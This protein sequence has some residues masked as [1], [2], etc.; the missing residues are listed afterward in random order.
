MKL[1]AEDELDD[2]EQFPDEEELAADL[3]DALDEMQNV[4]YSEPEEVEVPEMTEE[5]MTVNM[6]IDQELLAIA[7]EDDDGFH[8]NDRTESRFPDE[9]DIP[10]RDVCGAR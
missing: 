10:S 3:E 2:E 5:E 9:D 6:M 8:I 4:E 7:V 1:V